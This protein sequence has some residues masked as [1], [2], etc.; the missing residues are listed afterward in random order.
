VL[1][2]NLELLSKIFIRDGELALFLTIA[3]N[4]PPIRC[5]K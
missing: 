2:S 5:A 1:V 3:Q 4:P